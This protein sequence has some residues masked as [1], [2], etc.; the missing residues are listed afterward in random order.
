ML[1]SD[2]RRALFVHVPKTGGVSVGVTFR[3][4]C[5]DARSKAPDVTPP[6]GRHAPYERILRAEPQTLDYWSFAFVRNPWARMV[7]WWSM[8]SDWDREWGP[9][10]GKPQGAEAERMRGN[11]VWRAAAAYDGFEEF[12]LRG[13]DELPRVG[14]PQVDY[15]RSPTFE[16]EVDFVGRTETFAEDLVEVERRLGGTPTPTPHRNKSPHSIYRDYFSDVARDK[17]AAVYAADLEA[18]DYTF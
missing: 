3:R 9:S 4:C 8:I 14:R 15:L 2:S 5:D 6:L 12:V 16:R 11:D 7:S 1:I 18:F 13:T 10:S 17:V